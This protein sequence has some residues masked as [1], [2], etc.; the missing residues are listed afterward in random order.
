MSY[1]RL[2]LRHQSLRKG[3]TY[4]I[5]LGKGKL[6]TTLRLIVYKIISETPKRIIKIHMEKAASLLRAMM[7]NI[8]L[9]IMTV[10][11]LL[12][13]TVTISL[14]QTREDVFVLQRLK[15]QSVWIMPGRTHN[16]CS[17]KSWAKL[18]ENIKGGLDSRV[19]SSKN[20]DG[21]FAELKYFLSFVD[22]NVKKQ[23][24]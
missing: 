13:E 12:M 17:E 4:H 2:T 1:W 7:A 23:D 3:V 20:T 8:W 18:S 14:V 16:S 24:T 6:G 22:M 11:R 10:I 21:K 19:N 15:L 5:V 9:L